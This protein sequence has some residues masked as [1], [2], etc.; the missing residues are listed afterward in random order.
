MDR[1][2]ENKIFVGNLSYEVDSDDL[3]DVFESSGPVKYAKVL[4]D[5][6]TL[7]SRGFGFVQFEDKASFEDALKRHDE[8]FKGRKMIVNV[9]K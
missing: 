2:N 5:R 9:A 1:N 4:S 7:K 8:E 6:E 3:K